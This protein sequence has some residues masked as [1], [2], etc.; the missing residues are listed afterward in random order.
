MTVDQLCEGSPILLFHLLELLRISK[1]KLNQQGIDGDER[2]LL[3]ML[4][5]GLL[6]GFLRYF[7]VYGSFATSSPCKGKD[8]CLLTKSFL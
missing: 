7:A 6:Q 1:H 5:R 4:F 3:Y 2:D 8:P